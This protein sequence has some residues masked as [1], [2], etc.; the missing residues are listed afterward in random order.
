M[1]ASGCTIWT[2]A[3]TAATASSA[4]ACVAPGSSSGMRLHSFFGALL[5]G[6][7]HWPVLLQQSLCA[8]GNMKKRGHDTQPPQRS[9]ATMSSESSKL[10]TA[11]MVGLLGRKLVDPFDHHRMR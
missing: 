8:P 6:R 10:E 7:S 4:C 2:A 1:G 3:A 5:V 11:R 9:V